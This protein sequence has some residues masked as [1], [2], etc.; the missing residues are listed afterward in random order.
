MWGIFPKGCSTGGEAANEDTRGSR[1]VSDGQELPCLVRAEPARETPAPAQRSGLSWEPRKLHCPR[2]SVMGGSGRR[3]S[4]N[5]HSLD[6][7]ARTDS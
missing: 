4:P 1:R 6:C 3:P 5:S 7:L 2:S